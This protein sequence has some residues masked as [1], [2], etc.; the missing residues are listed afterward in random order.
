PER[1]AKLGNRTVLVS[2]TAKSGPVMLTSRFVDLTYS[3]IGHRLNNSPGGCSGGRRASGS[4]VAMGSAGADVK[5]APEAG[6]P[7]FPAAGST[8][9]PSVVGKVEANSSPGRLR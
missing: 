7:A 2:F 9:W 8:D 3:D 5:F 4:G 6:V 1:D